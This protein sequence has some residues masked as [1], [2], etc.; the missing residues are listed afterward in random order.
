MGSEIMT[1]KQSTI[2]AIQESKVILVSFVPYGDKTKISFTWHTAEH[3]YTV[4]AWASIT[5]RKYMQLDGYD[6][7]MAILKPSDFTGNRI[8]K[9][10]GAT[11][12]NENSKA[13][14]GAFEA[15]CNE[16]ATRTD[17]VH[18]DQ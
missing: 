4:E 17:K 8:K 2:E 9:A 13:C 12:Y 18:R 7:L 15:V 6:S 16:L 14:K 11:Q 10:D 3:A 1:I 5:H